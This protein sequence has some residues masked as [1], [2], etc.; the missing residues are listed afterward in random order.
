VKATSELANELVPELIDALGGADNIQ[1]YGKGAI[2]GL[3]G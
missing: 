1:A 2:V 3:N